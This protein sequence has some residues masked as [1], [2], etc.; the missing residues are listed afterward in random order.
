MKKT[1]EQQYEVER[2]GAVEYVVMRCPNGHRLRGMKA[3]SMMVRQDVSCTECGWTRMVLAPMTN[4]ME[5]VP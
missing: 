5:L 1:K 3:G 4:G 2:Q